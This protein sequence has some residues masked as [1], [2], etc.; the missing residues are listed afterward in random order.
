MGLGW[1]QNRVKFQKMI[2]SSFLHNCTKKEGSPTS[3]GL[4]L[5]IKPWRQNYR[6]PM[7][8]LWGFFYCHRKPIVLPPWFN[9]QIQTSTCGKTFFFVTFMQKTRVYHFLKFDPIS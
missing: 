6:L 3:R 5:K 7:G 9:L 4:N 2:Y 1:S 8:L